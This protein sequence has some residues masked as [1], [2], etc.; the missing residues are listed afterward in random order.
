MDVFIM[1]Y[2]KNKTVHKLKKTEK[3]HPVYEDKSDSRVKV[4]IV[5]GTLI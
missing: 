4:L 2:V 1:T 5:R 3:K